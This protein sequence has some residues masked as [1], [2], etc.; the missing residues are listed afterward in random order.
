MNAK[1][2]ATKGTDRIMRSLNWLIN[3]RTIILG[4]TIVYF[5]VMAL[6]VA[7]WYQKYGQGRIAV[8]PD[9]LGVPMFLIAAAALLWSRRWWSELLAI[10]PGGRVLYMSYVGFRGNPFVSDIDPSFRVPLRIWL[11]QTYALQPQEFLEITLAF[12]IFC[13]ALVALSQRSLRHN[14]RSKG[15]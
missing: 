7:R 6:R 1:L 15:Q 2:N 11:A 3:P 14:T 9:W 5:I 8:Y 10:L 4:V 13:Y 12:V